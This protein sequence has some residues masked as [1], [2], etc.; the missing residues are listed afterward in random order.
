M[1]N[2]SRMVERFILPEEQDVMTSHAIKEKNIY[3]L[4]ENDKKI[5]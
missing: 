3:N 5:S 1:K 2:Q 4:I